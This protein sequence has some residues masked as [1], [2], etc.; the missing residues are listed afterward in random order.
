MM[1]IPYIY[2]TLRRHSANER[3]VAITYKYIMTYFCGLYHYGLD[4]LLLLPL[5]SIREAAPRGVAQ[6][7][8]GGTGGARAWLKRGKDQGLSMSRNENVLK[9]AGHEVHVS[10][11]TKFGLLR[12]AACNGRA[13]QEKQPAK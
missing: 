11:G 8:R 13:V 5:P 3:H 12:S 9:E 6:A 4:G 10:P 2:S 1:R 7:L